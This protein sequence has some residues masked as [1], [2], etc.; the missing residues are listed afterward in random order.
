M[1]DADGG[2]M[3]R[4]AIETGGQYYYITNVNQLADVYQAISDIIFGRYSL[5]YVS[6]LHG[7]NPI[8]L[9]IDVAAGAD[10]GAGVPQTTGCP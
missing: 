5:K 7:G 6:S 1:G 10:E 3:N 2:V 9:N 8:T 4:L